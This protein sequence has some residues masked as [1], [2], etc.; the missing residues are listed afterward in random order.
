MSSSSHFN[1]FN[2]KIWY[3][4]CS[5]ETCCRSRH[6][7]S[8]P[9]WEEAE[10]ATAPKSDRVSPPRSTFFVVP[11]TDAFTKITTEHSHLIPSKVDTG[12]SSITTYSGH[13]LFTHSKYTLA[14]LLNFWLLHGCMPIARDLVLGSTNNFITKT[15]NQFQCLC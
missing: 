2:S 7:I 14:C 10:V 1:L 6:K 4:S 3:E 12:Y 15:M 8:S 13:V 11:Y 5:C 9:P